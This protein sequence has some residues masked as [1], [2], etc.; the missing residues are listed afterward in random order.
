LKKKYFLLIGWWLVLLG[1]LDAQPLN[2]EHFGLKEGF[3]ASQVSCILKDKAGFIW[4]ATEVG[5]YRYDGHQFKSFQ[6]EPDS[7]NTLST[8]YIFTL[9]TDKHNR[10]WVGGLR[11]LDVFCIE[12]FEASRYKEG[13][14]QENKLGVRQFV[15]DKG[16]DL[17]WIVT[18]RGLFFSQGQDV[19][20]TPFMIQDINF[21]SA[22]RISL[23]GNDKI[24]ISGWDGLFIYDMKLC[25][26]TKIQI[27]FSYGKVNEPEKFISQYLQGDTIL[28]TGS[29]DWGLFRFDLRTGAI[30]QFLYNS[31]QGHQNGIRAI[32][33]DP[34]N[35]DK[36]WLATTDGI[37]SYDIS[38]KNFTN[39]ITSNYYDNSGV[40]GEGTCF[41][42]SASEGLWVGT[43]KGLHRLDPHN[44]FVKYIGIPLSVPYG[45]KFPTRVVFEK[46]K[47]NRDSIIWFGQNFGGIFRYDLINK[48]YVSIPDIFKEYCEGPVM[49]NILYSDHKGNL[50][51]SSD[52]HQL[53]AANLQTYQPVNLPEN[54]AD[55]PVFTS[56]CSDG[57]N[58]IWLN[59][60]DGIYFFDYDK[61]GK[62]YKDSVL[63]F[64]F[65]K[66]GYKSVNSQI[67][68]W[69]DEKLI[70]TMVDPVKNVRVGVIYYP[71][72][73]KIFEIH[74][75]Q[76]SVMKKSHHIELM[77]PIAQNSY[78]FTSFNNGIYLLKEQSEKFEIS[79]FE[80]AGSNKLGAT[81]FICQGSD[82][83]VYFS[84]DFGFARFDRNSSRITPVYNSQ[85]SKGNWNQSQIYFSTATGLY[86]I[87]GENAL[88]Y[89]HKN[90]FPVFSQNSPK[91]VELNVNNKEQRIG[92]SGDSTLTFTHEENN[93]TFVFTSFSYTNGDFC[94]YSYTLFKNNK[95]EFTYEGT[96]RINFATLSP[97]AYILNVS[98]T[99]FIGKKSSENCIIK[100]KIK[101]PFYKSWTFFILMFAFMIGLIYNFFRLK[102]MQRQKLL[103]L[104]NNIAKDL[105]DDM[106][107][108]LSYIK[109]LS[110]VESMK[111][112][113]NNSFQ[114]INEK[115]DEVMSMMSE[116]IWNINPNYDSLILVVAKIQ[117]YAIERLEPR[118]IEL[119]FNASNISD[120][121]KLSPAKKRSVYLICKEAINNAAKYSN[122]KTLI[123]KIGMIGQMISV[124]IKD[125]GVGFDP[126]AISYGN[127]LKNM[128]NR[129]SDLGG[130]LNITTDENGTKIY[131]QFNVS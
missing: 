63:F 16:V 29:W 14:F 23:L 65:K 9:E 112:K 94:T 18:E 4:L 87:G 45:Y 35:P 118:N 77:F 70:F 120:K 126:I 102:D 10:L 90:S 68:A 1:I 22:S 83:L 95:Q 44:N 12:S 111:L 37:I 19:R 107:G 123:I 74:P 13:D 54:K 34:Q 32:E 104:R 75:D 60:S 99:N 109:I 78:L 28:W 53:F 61:P 33:S 69:K 88:Y 101:A 46:N 125:D 40:T 21:S 20:L 91:L 55:L 116:I 113:E 11:S 115:T 82:S 8:N 124:L 5:L 105:H 50:W 51:I 3:N 41:Y 71:N 86:Y 98:A 58:R 47:N 97:G 24:L 30:N 66:K 114:K 39:Y 64:H 93:I 110:E 96:N 79:H 129:A 38:S 73:G 52:S 127:G 84:T 43:L 85:I 122:A 6:Y 80:F 17:M 56:I 62:I 42:S 59:S 31:F 76:F 2:F 15:Y 49:P 119:I 81:R 92:F 103:Q 27:P 108:T 117:E 26:S 48:S 89:F 128:K 25:K 131:F 7:I 57:L 36:L 100:F 72:T 67:Y 130:A 121:I 106:G